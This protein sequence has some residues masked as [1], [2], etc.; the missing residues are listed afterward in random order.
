MINKYN[1]KFKI[2][3]SNL[4]ESYISIIQFKGNLSKENLRELGWL[5]TGQ[6]FSVLLGFI[7]I[8]MIS[9]MGTFE[10]GKYSLILSIAAII[11]T[12]FYG[13]IEQGY[14]RFYFDYKKN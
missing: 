1:Y 6:I 4:I 12:I 7:S 2:I 13:P 14:I 8:K 3:R 11:S 5:I 9:T 10:F